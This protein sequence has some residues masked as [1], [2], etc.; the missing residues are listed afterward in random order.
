M[1][2][3]P[4][5][6][7]ACTLALNSLSGHDICPKC[8]VKVSSHRHWQRRLAAGDVKSP[9]RPAELPF[10]VERKTVTEQVRMKVAPGVIKT[11]AKTGPATIHAPKVPPPVE[12][13]ADYGVAETW[14]AAFDAAAASGHLNPGEVANAK[15]WKDRG[16]AP[17]ELKAGPSP[18][19]NAVATYIDEAAAVEALGRAGEALEIMREFRI[20]QESQTA[21]SIREEML[22]REPAHPYLTFNLPSEPPPPSYAPRSGGPSPKMNKHPSESAKPLDGRVRGRRRAKT[23]AMALDFVSLLRR[24]FRF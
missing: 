1:K 12:I 10:T 20:K 21:R 8:K 5:D 4:V 16:P 17:A 9:W 11:F 14:C 24:A 6:P 15:A 18:L 22:G 2:P 19:S 7:L 23:K 3:G 13:K